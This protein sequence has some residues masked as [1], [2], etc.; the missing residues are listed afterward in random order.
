MEPYTDAPVIL[1]TMDQNK[2]NR[3]I[4]PFFISL[5]VNNLL[6]HNCMLDSGASSDVMIRK[7]ME[8]LNLRISR[9][10]HNVCAM[11]SREI[12]VHVLFNDLQVHLAVFPD[13]SV[14]MDVAIDV[15]DAWGMLLSRE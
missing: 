1:Q 7:V 13:M 15:P 12:E 3:G 14:L 9:P 10:Y 11:D 4:Q 6:L 5:M 8:R 2:G